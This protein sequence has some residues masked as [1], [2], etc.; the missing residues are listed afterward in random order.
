MGLIEKI[1]SAACNLTSD[2]NVCPLQRVSLSSVRHLCYWYT[3]LPNVHKN[4]H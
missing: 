2:L 4:K 3:P 1:G